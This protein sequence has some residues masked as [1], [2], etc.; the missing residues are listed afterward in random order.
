[1]NFK[2]FLTTTILIIGC[3][4]LAIAQKGK[5][6]NPSTVTT[7]Q[8]DV[9]VTYAKY[10]GKT[11]RLRDLVPLSPTTPEKRKSKK[12]DKK[13][14]IPNFI[15]RGKY[16]PTD[17][18]QLSPY[19]DPVRQLQ[20]N[21]TKSPDVPVEPIVN[22]NGLTSNSIPGDP[23]GDIGLDYYI[24]GVNATVFRVYDKNGTA[25]TAGIA[26]NTLWNDLGYS[27]GGDIIILFDQEVNRWIITEFPGGST[28]ILLFAISET[29]DPTGAWMAYEF[30]TP[31]F[32]DYPKYGV[33]NNS[34]VV[35]TN[36]GG[37]GNI[38]TYYINRQ[39]I[40]DG[41]ASPRIQRIVFSGVGPGSGVGFYTGSPVDWSGLTPP[42][43]NP[44]VLRLGDDAWAGF[45]TDRVDVISVDVDWDTPSNTSN[46]VTSIPLSAF[47]TDACAA[48]GSNF[49]CVPQLGGDGI[50]GSPDIIMN[51]PHYRNF[52]THES[53]V[54]CFLV[55]ANTPQDI[56]AGIRWVELRKMP[57]MNWEL[58]QEGTWA[59]DDGIH[60]FMGSIAMDGNGNIGL[61]YS[62]SSP[63]IY[64]GLAFTGRYAE[65]PLGEMSVIEYV[66]VDGQS[67]SPLPRW[68]D[69]SHL[70]IDPTGNNT[71]WFTSE[72]R[73]ANATRTRI[74]SFLLKR[75]TTDIGVNA[76]LT[77]QNSPD[78]TAT[79]TIQIEVKNFGLD[80]LMSYDVG[81]IFENGT[82]VLETI[83]QILLPD[84]TYLHSFVSTV[85]MSVV[86]DYDLKLFTSLPTDDAVFNDTLRTIIAKFPRDDAGITNISGL[87]GSNCVDPI[88]AEVTLT[89]FGVNPLT[90]ANIDFIVNG[91]P[92]PTIAWTGNLM[93]G[94]SENIAIAVTDLVN[95]DN[96]ISAY[97]SVPNGE[98]DEV[99]ANDTT[100]RS[101]NVVLN[102]VDITL[103]INFDQFPDETSWELEDLNGNVL[104]AGGPYPGQSN[105]TFTETFCLLPYDCYNFTI[106]D[107]FGDGICCNQGSG[108]YNITDAD[109]NPLL[110]GDGDF[111]SSASTDFCATFVCTLEGDVDTAPE[112]AT[113]AS[114]ATIMITPVNGVG[115]FTYSIDGGTNFQSNNIFDD[116]GAGV[117]NIVIND[118]A[119][120]IYEQTIEVVTCALS[121]TAIV[122][123]VSQMGA[124]D[125]GIEITGIDGF[126]Q[127][128][129]SLN[130]VIFGNNNAFG[131]LPAGDYTVFVRD[132]VGCQTQVDVTVDVM[133]S[134]QEVTFGTSVEV[135][136]NPTSGVFRI[137]VIG[138]DRSDVF[139]PYEIYDLSGKRIQQY[140]LVKYDDIYTSEISLV[141]YP[142]GTYFVRF[143]DKNMD[144]LVKV[145]KE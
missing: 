95:A 1:M 43:S 79:E 81:Y 145:A 78:L 143:L 42:N 33:W 80:T 89:N 15:G 131:F 24:Q 36:E 8:A 135:M 111:G 10:I 133:T 4:C 58:Y 122:T 116:L 37:P 93:M 130:G 83:N 34:Y 40:L 7:E 29:S 125:G 114:D 128:Q 106:F 5:K 59:P 49:A 12:K 16:Q 121:A 48:P 92:Q 30:G 108:N 20:Q 105:Q 98:I 90:S 126:G 129:Y 68:C 74:A 39:D 77:P 21:L 70:S 17:I 64:P 38:E 41:A 32:P 104:F 119:G 66:L 112:S 2:S 127:L 65:D 132:S 134:L 144:R 44:M 86:G 62:I 28:N 137:N 72:Y 117:Y 118:A 27:S 14:E 54:L 25:V 97:A 139:L 88:A 120:C 76:L 75:D 23:T 9:S 102:G 22:Q 47:N 103:T 142:A 96:Q 101:F 18:S 110:Q 63:D 82:A 100:T 26:A 45:N 13:K 6:P 115:P 11:K 138:L 52:G 55:N 51:Q 60:R 53:I 46:V 69:Y 67:A 61:A 123:N 109:G 57:G 113:S 35:T 141:A 85:D 124:V 56:I 140:R 73:T 50:D 107:G 136:P 99:S 31:N 84:S 71:F 87:D 3:W 91:I 19:P 94:A